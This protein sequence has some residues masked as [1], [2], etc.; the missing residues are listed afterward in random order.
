MKKNKII[1][2]GTNPRYESTILNARIRKSYLKNKVEIYVTSGSGDLTYPY[3]IIKNETKEIPNSS[4]ILAIIRLNRK[5]NNPM[6]FEYVVNEQ[7]SSLELP[8]IT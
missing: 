4:G 5:S 2:I 6:S 8:V 1:L 7:G 3:E